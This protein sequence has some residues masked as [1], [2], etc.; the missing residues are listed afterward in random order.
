MIR[1]VPDTLRE[2]LLRPLAMTAPDGGVY[3]EIMAPDFRFVFLFLLVVAVLL[4]R[5]RRKQTIKIPGSISQL[6]VV[7]ALAFV[8]WLVITGNG[9]YF[10]Q[11]LLISGV[12]CVGLINCLPLS[13]FFRASLAVLLTSIQIAAV[14]SADPF[15]AWALATWRDAPYFDLQK[16]QKPRDEAQTIVTISTITYSLLAPQFPANIRWSNITSSPPPTQDRLESRYA[17]EILANPHGVSLF[18]P[19][20]KQLATSEHL[21]GAGIRQAINNM[22]EDY[23]LVLQRAD[24]CEFLLSKGLDSLSL[25][26]RGAESSAQQGFWL[27]P[28]ERVELKSKDVTKRKGKFAAVFEAVEIQCPRFFK[29]DTANTLQIQGGELRQYGGSDMKLYVLEDGDVWYKY[30]RAIN[31]VRLGSREEILTGRAPVDCS[32]ILGRSGLPWERGL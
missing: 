7:T 18:V 27:C 11:F 20:I 26:Q 10:I 21:P 3:V 12:L 4:G 22:I 14:M 6:L 24:A 8:I 15:N 9:R 23:G 31:P 13:K 32:K 5:L 1:F 28:L 17:K 19:A 16:P 30:F 25:R 2:A 29:P